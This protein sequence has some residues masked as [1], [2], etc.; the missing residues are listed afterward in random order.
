MSGQIH[1]RRQALRCWRSS[2]RDWVSPSTALRRHGSCCTGL[3]RR[4][5]QPTGRLELNAKTADLAASAWLGRTTRDFFDVDVAE[6]AEELNNRLGWASR[7]IDL[8][9]G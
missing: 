8:P 3:R 7:K 2:R 5:V 9:P 6:A 4:G 1:R